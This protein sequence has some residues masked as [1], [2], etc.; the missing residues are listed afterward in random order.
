MHRYDDTRFQQV[1]NFGRLGGAY[2]GMSAHWHEK[3]I[4]AGQQLDLLL[5]WDVSQIAQV[6]DAQVLKLDAVGGVAAGLS[7]PLAS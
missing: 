3:D 6:A 4:G 1:D 5:V 2:S 7:P